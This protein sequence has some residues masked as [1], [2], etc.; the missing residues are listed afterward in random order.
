MYRTDFTFWS[1]VY[2][3]LFNLKKQ[4]KL[5]NIF[6]NWVHLIS[7]TYA[8]SRWYLLCIFLVVFVY[9]WLF[10]YILVSKFLTHSHDFSSLLKL[11]LIIL[12]LLSWH[13]QLKYMCRFRFKYFDHVWRSD[14]GKQSYKFEYSNILLPINLI[15]L[16][17]FNVSQ[18]SNIIYMD[19]MRISFQNKFQLT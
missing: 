9:F 16:R 6:C 15:S 10:S 13:V 19:L 4:D 2:L 17:I 12:K 14:K 1:F 7:C 3:S 11:A 5:C 8:I 18:I